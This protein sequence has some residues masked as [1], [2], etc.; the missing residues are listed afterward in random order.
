[1][2]ESWS[3]WI[4]GLVFGVVLAVAYGTLGTSVLFVGLVLLSVGAVMSRS[5]AFL[6]GGLVGVGGGWTALLVSAQLRC[7]EFNSHPNQGCEPPD[8]T[9]WLVQGAIALVIGLV[10]G[11][12]AV[13]RRRSHVSQAGD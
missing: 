11:A 1:V 9:P 12:L 10:F 3:N 6:S 8:L 4:T 13:H 5:M 2:R 7:I